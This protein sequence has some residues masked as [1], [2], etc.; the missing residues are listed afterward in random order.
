M[1]SEATIEVSLNSEPFIQFLTTINGYFARRGITLD[2]ME[3]DQSEAF[4]I[5]TAVEKPTARNTVNFVARPS[6]RFIERIAR[7]IVD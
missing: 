6:D 3:L 4:T 7:L 5:E 1:A 2:E